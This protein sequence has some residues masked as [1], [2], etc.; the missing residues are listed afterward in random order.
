MTWLQTDDRMDETQVYEQLS[1]RSHRLHVAALHF[2]A[3]NETDGVVPKHRAGRLIPGRVTPAQ[4]RELIDA[5]LW[6]DQGASYMLSDFLARHANKPHAWW[7]ARREADRIR[8][9]PVE[10]P[11]RFDADSAG[12]PDAPA[13]PSPSEPDAYAS[14]SP[15]P[16]RGGRADED[17]QSD[18]AG[19]LADWEE[20]VRVDLELL[21]GALSR[22]GSGAHS[23]DQPSSA[24]A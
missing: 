10:K 11:T 13:Q 24:Q 5:G 7:E 6:V 14:R 4:V 23:R 8:K 2:S 22:N 15:I 20:P 19:R 17:H 12:I 21:R 16:A 9:T 1:D 18:I 3:R